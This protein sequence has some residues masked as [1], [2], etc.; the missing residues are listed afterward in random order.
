ML[1]SLEKWFEEFEEEC[2]RILENQKYNLVYPSYDY[3]L[4]CSHIFNLLD[5]RGNVS[6]SE[7]PDMIGRVRHLA[8]RIA[9][10]YVNEN[11]IN[12]RSR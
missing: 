8:Q 6:I 9:K 5:A 3:M 7:R 2:L 11:N 4:K 12:T 1:P 10:N